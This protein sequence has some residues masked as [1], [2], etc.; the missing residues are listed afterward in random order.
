[1]LVDESSR[2]VGRYYGKFHA[3][4]VDNT[5]DDHRGLLRVEVPDVFGAGVVVT[6]EACLPYG[7][8]F[9]PP[10]DTVVWVE[11][12]AGDPERPLWTG[13]ALTE[14]TRTKVPPD[15]ILIHHT[16]D[17]MISI[18]EQGGLLLSS[19][20]GSYVHLDA[21]HAAA[22]LAEGHGNFLSMGAD[23]VSLVNNAGT[24][25][26]ITKDTVHIR[27]A[28]VV[29]EAT[30]VA[31]GAGAADTA[32]LGSGMEALWTLLATHV[33]PTAGVG[34]PSPSPQFAAV[35]KLIPGVHLSSAVVLR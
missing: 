19:P 26:N 18:D 32:V 17:A 31:L 11:F 30:T 33:H 34:P 7:H 27:A 12:E 5:D 1:M 20:S 3:T 8:Y 2:H 10:K 24:V 15:S 35:P 29:V 28:K 13:V 4:V 14:A 22:T 25:I 9:V 16:G 23:G 6:A 21:E